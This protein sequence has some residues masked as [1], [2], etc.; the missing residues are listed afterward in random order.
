MLW[1]SIKI[2][3]NNSIIVANSLITTN[4]I[5]ATNCIITITNNT[6]AT[7]S[8][9]ITANNP[10]N[11]WTNNWIPGISPRACCYRLLSNY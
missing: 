2:R 6:I 11:N 7:N 8:L 1:L 3:N 5:R 4:N 10:I 9:I